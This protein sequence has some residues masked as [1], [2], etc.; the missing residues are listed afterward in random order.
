MSGKPEPETPTPSRRTR[1]QEQREQQNQTPQ[2]SGSREVVLASGLQALQITTGPNTLDMS[3]IQNSEDDFSPFFDELNRHQQRNEYLMSI[4]EGTFADDDR[5][6]KLLA[7]HSQ[8][9]VLFKP[10]RASAKRHR[11][12]QQLKEGAIRATRNELGDAF[13]DMYQSNMGDNKTQWDAIRRLCKLARDHDINF[14]RAWR[15]AWSEA[16]KRIKSPGRG[17]SSLAAIT[18]SDL[19]NVEKAMNGG[20]KDAVITDQ[21]LPRPGVNMPTTLDQNRI[22][23]L[24]GPPSKRLTETNQPLPAP[25]PWKETKAG[26]KRHATPPPPGSSEKIEKPKKP[27]PADSP[28]LFGDP[29]ND[30]FMGESTAKRNVRIVWKA[31]PKT[32]KKVKEEQ[33]VLEGTPSRSIRHLASGWKSGTPVIVPIVPVDRPQYGDMLTDKRL[34]PLQQALIQY[35]YQH[36]LFLTGQRLSVPD[37]MAAPLLRNSSPT[38]IRMAATSLRRLIDY[39]APE[40]TR[41]NPY[42][43]QENQR[44]WWICGLCQWLAGIAFWDFM[45]DPSWIRETR[46]LLQT[47]RQA[48]PVDPAARG[49]DARLQL[50][51]TVAIQRTSFS[52]DEWLMD[53]SGRFLGWAN[54]DTIYAALGYM[55]RQHPQIDIISPAHSTA[56]RNRV[57]RIDRYSTVEAP[58]I[59]PDAR[60][61]L[62]P[63]N[64]NN[65]HWVLGFINHETHRIGILDSMN[66]MTD[67][68]ILRN[69]LVEIGDNPD[70]YWDYEGP[71]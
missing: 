29:D 57:L 55:A 33:L 15:M 69:L 58:A 32:G 24:S 36:T 63:I 61:V 47:I 7:K 60:Q 39:H 65:N 35:H 17:R 37:P 27:H 12:T 66:S 9:Q 45:Q 50:T 59:H 4:I 67:P 28:G 53:S 64:L 2:A 11:E 6:N 38:D 46:A 44:F 30:P 40:A 49:S 42:N 34:T 19:I 51:H 70:D 13:M 71:P 48:W 62:I 14:L 43:A 54:D 22:P 25:R 56:Y 23:W 21:D 52:D 18:Q 5:F 26:G 1:G 20:T 8:I 16:L 10:V 31:D 68:G 41:S 3:R